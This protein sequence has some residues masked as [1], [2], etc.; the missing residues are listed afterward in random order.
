ME[1]VESL[2]LT[3]EVKQ[4]I[5]I[6][7]SIA[8]EFSNENFSS[9]HLLKA[10]LHKEID[11]ISFLETIGKDNYY[12]EEWAEV[13]I[14][15]YPK[16]SRIPDKP[17]ADKEAQ[18]VFLEAENI[19][20]KLSKD[21]IDP[22]CLLVALSTP[23][24]GFSYE[25]LKS[26]NLTSQEI[27][28]SIIEK[29]ELHDA[30]GKST[31]TETEK[32]KKKNQN[33]ILKYCS[34]LSAMARQ[35]LLDPV[36][37]R[38]K[39]HRMMAEILGR[40]TK[41]NVIIIG[42]PGTGKTSLVMGFAQHISENRVSKNL[43]DTHIFELDFG[44]LIAGA[45]YKGEVEERFKNIILEISQFDK[46]ILF[47]D[48][49]H[50]VLDKQ[51]GATGVVNLLKP[52]LDKGTLTLIGTT[53]IDN[54]TKFVESDDSF[55]PRFEIIKLEEPGKELTI[56]ILNHI[57]PT[58]SKHHNV[59]VDNDVIKEA[60]RLAQRYLKERCL[61]DSAIDLV[62]RGMSVVR[63]TKDTSEKEVQELISKLEKISNN[64]TDLPEDVLIKEMKWFHLQIKEKVSPLL[65]LKLEHE[66][67]IEEV[68]DSK[69]LFQSLTT[70]LNQLKE[71]SVNLSNSL[72]KSDLAAV[73][74]HKTGVPIGKVQ[75]QERERL[76]NT[77]LHLMER[78]VGQ[79]HA[80]TSIAEAIRESRSGLSKPGQPIGSFFF[81]GPTGTGKT[82]LAKTLAEFL[83]ND[84]NSLLRFDMSEFKEEHSAA[85]L[86]GAPPGYVGYEE[87]GLLVN[88]IR[89]K[90]YSIVLFDEI[91][92]AHVSVFDIFLQILDEGKLHDRLGK[93]GDFSNAV[94]LFTSNIGSAH[95][96]EVFA[97]GK[98]PQSN[99]LSEI[100]EAYFRPEFLG[101]L[102]EIV[103]FAPI[104]EENI[105]K[106]FE[107]HLKSLFKSLDTLGITL[108]I[109]QAAKEELA[110]SGF[111]P[112]YG[113]R[114]LLG[115]IRNKLRR[116]MSKMILSGEIERGSIISLSMD[117]N[118]KLIWKK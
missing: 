77:E 94:I 27:L 49:I 112:K 8:K 74:A 79:D 114:P 97:K 102:T 35:D 95:I 68:E 3:K 73:V 33:A 60:V 14:E 38:D 24:V 63:F 10:I 7:Q 100:M 92:K 17:L 90:P 28:N 41:P 30:L 117:K 18:A 42:E 80:I 56:R 113:A 116:P 16:S 31:K 11:L 115:V 32:T 2:R 51:G 109:E 71:L 106:I 40:R 44:A 20:L 105:V 6:A 23:G 19:S 88:K 21:V 98:I 85:L 78:V 86:Y 70:L 87:G 59:S 99:E 118:N 58:Y 22:I 76:L 61:P 26:F 55:G 53:S 5:T 9:A 67:S 84:E 66:L 37:G 25:Q 36:I 107:I 46:A 96:S 82:E 13:R 81:L 43:I 83:F 65:F 93:V 45:S 110:K 15:A 1:E 89:Q 69:E 50:R 4:A 52:E 91:E 103:P 64:N 57:L 108:Q 75:T 12:M 48:D 72:T 39:E 47:V 62:D 54:Y 34:D 104:S 29:D 111:T 101:R